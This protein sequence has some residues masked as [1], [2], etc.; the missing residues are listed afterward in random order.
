MLRVFAPQGL[1]CGLSVVLYGLLQSYRR[2]VAP[3]IGSEGLQSGAHRLPP[4]VRAAGQGASA[5]QP[6]EQPDQASQLIG[7]FVPFAPGFRGRR[8]DREPVPGHVRDRPA[9]GR[10]RGA[11]QRPG[12][13]RAEN[14]VTAPLPGISRPPRAKKP[15]EPPYR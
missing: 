3:S 14:L 11:G 9:Q 13:G 5:V 8:G 10:R 4:G 15:G 2:F 1:L 7:A 6:A 12:P